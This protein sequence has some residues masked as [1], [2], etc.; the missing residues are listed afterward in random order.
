MNIFIEDFT[1]RTEVFSHFSARS[2]H[3]APTLGSEELDEQF[4]RCNIMV[5]SYDIQGYEGT[6]FVLFEDTEDGKLYEVNGSHCSCYGLEGQWEPEEVSPESLIH[7][8]ENG[9]IIDKQTTAAVLGVAKN[10]QEEREEAKN[11][12]IFS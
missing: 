5:A 1:D 7:R 9:K 8:C 11:Y 3:R 10:I 2:R 12:P 4:A 6:A